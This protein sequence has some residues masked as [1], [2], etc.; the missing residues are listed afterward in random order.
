MDT[1]GMKMLLNGSAIAAVVTLAGAAHAAT[2]SVDHDGPTIDIFGT[3]EFTGTGTYTLDAFGAALGG[4][5]FTASNNGTLAYLF[6]DANSSM[7]GGIGSEITVEVTASQ[8]L[9]WTTNT[10]RYELD[11]FFVMAD[12]ITDGSRENLRLSTTELGYRTPD[13]DTI[14]FEA[15]TVPFV[16]AE[17]DTPTV[18]IP[19]SL[20]ILAFGL[21]MLTVAGR[22]TA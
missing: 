18:P 13:R 9:L 16:L 3:I 12:V 5:S 20:P 14:V 6:T 15:A 4:Y 8:I 10:A 21:G 19:A 11:G 22:R 17:I 2:Y 7:G 1:S